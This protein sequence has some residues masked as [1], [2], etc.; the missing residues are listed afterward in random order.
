MTN[1]SS[2]Y[3]Q[4]TMVSFDYID[5][6]PKILLFKTHHLWNSTTELILIVS[7]QCSWLYNSFRRIFVED[8]WKIFRRIFSDNFRSIFQ[9]I[10][11]RI[12]SD[13]FSEDFSEEFVRFFGNFWYLTIGEIHQFSTDNLAIYLM[14]IESFDR[15]FTQ[16]RDF[17]A[18]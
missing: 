11:Q 4:N 14:Q 9:R 10:F 17:L 2:P 5:F 15:W 3:S 16:L 6:W 12:S 13:N 7:S 8:L 18:M 1:W